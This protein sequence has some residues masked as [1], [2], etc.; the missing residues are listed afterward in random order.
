MCVITQVIWHSELGKFMK[1]QNIKTFQWLLRREDERKE[2]KGGGR[3]RQVTVGLLM[4][5]VLY[6]NTM[7]GNKTFNF[8]NL[9]HFTIGV[10]GLYLITFKLKKRKSFRAEV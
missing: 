10:S 3:E 1:L 5:T 6:N 9:L 7:V 2:R 4:N 8:Q